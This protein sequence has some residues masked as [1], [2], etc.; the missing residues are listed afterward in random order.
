[1]KHVPGWYDKC[2]N[3]DYWTHFRTSEIKYPE[4]SIK[5]TTIHYNYK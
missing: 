1:M 2:T 4:V 3:E 5:I